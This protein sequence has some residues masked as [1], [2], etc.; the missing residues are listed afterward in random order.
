MEHLN[1]TYPQIV[2]VFVAQDKYN[3]GYSEKL[4]CDGVPC[5]HYVVHV[6]NHSTLPDETRPEIFISG[7]LHG[8]ERLGPQ[9]AIEL[10]KLMADY[11]KSFDQHLKGNISSDSPSILHTKRWIYQLVNTRSVYIMPMTNPYGYANNVRSELRIDP[12]RDYNYMKPPEQCMQTMTS[13][14]VNEIW[15]D[16]IFQLAVTFHG[17]TRSIAYEWGSTNHYIDKN[18]K[19]SEKSPDDMAQFDL[20]NLLSKYGGPFAPEEHMENFGEENPNNEYYPTGMMNEAVYGVDGGMEDWGYAASWENSVSKMKPFQPCHPTTFGGYDEAKTIYNNVTHRAFNILVETSNDKIP[21]N[22]SLGDSSEIYATD[23]DFYNANE[24]I[25]VGHVTRNIRL[26]L[27]LIE[28]VQPYV[29]WINLPKKN[30]TTIDSNTT[31][32]NSSSLDPSIHQGSFSPSSTSFPS[33]SETSTPTPSYSVPDRPTVRELSDFV[34]ADSFLKQVQQSV[35]V[36]CDNQVTIGST[37]TCNSTHCEITRTS[38]RNDSLQ[39]AWEV[40]GSLIVDETFLEVSS[41]SSFPP[42]GITIVMIHI[43]I[44]LIADFSS[45]LL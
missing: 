38:G 28:M 14:V 11:S 20:A 12:N 18:K 2:Q 43:M 27:M 31:T 25:A 10:I 15:R 41:N 4:D 24:K 26:A 21:K 34:S 35:Q 3:L 23:L 8:D 42:K 16:H 22:S 33:A 29:R 17:G 5:K 44:G 32:A 36:G 39:L 6:T 37:L 13:R 1:A 40:L 45:H 19:R 9:A 30:E 7:A